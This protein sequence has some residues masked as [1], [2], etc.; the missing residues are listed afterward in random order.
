MA[1]VFGLGITKGGHGAVLKLVSA[2]GLGLEAVLDK[3]AGCSD[4]ISGRKR[5]I[6]QVS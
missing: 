6:L 5:P 1:S 2:E 4:G 3:H